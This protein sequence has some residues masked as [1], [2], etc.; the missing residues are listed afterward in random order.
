M[1]V[2]TNPDYP[3]L[4]EA[5]PYPY[6]LIAPDF[7]LIGANPAYLRATGRT[8]NDILGKHI[9]DAFPANPADPDATNIKEVSRSIELAFSTQKPH[10]SALLRY[11]IPRQTEQG[12]VFDERFWSAVHTPV[13]NQQGNVAFVS[14]N[15]ID[16][17]DLYRFDPT[18]KHYFLKPSLNAVPDAA[19][20]ASPLMHEAMTR[21]LS[22]ER[23]QLQMLFNQAPGFIAILMGK[24]HVFEMVNEAYYQLVG[25]RD[26]IGKAVWEALPEVVGQGYEALLNG[27]L[28]SGNAVVLQSQKLLVQRLPNGPLS[29]SY[30]DLVYQPLLDAE[31]RVIGIFAQGHDVTKAYVATEELKKKVQ[32]LEE[33][34]ARQSFQLQIAEILRSHSNPA[35][36]LTKTSKIIGQHFAVSRVLFGDYEVGQKQITFHSNYTDGTVSE[37]AGTFPATAFGLANFEVLEGGSTWV[38]HDTAND[39]RTSGPTVWPSF[40]SSNILSGVA[41]PLNSHGQMIACLFVNAC[42]PRHWTG[43]AVNL[44][45]DAAE[46]IW[47]AVERSRAEGALKQADRRKD[48]FLAMLAHELRNPLAPIGAAAELLQ[49]VKP[50]EQRLRQTSQI[51]GRQ[52]K[53]MTSLVDDL[54]DVSRVTRGLVE[55]DK[56]TYDIRQIVNEAVEQVT[57]L[58]LSKRHH[59]VL[60]LPPETANV[61]G[62]K[63]RLVQVIANLLNNAAK[64]TPEGGNILLK[65]EVDHALVHVDVIDNGVG[66]APELVTRVF[67]LFAQAERSSDRS[68]GGLGLGLA[69]VK[70]LIELHR[71]TVSCQSKGI[72]EGS[73]FRVCMPR[74]I[75]DGSQAEPAQNE[76]ALHSQ[77]AGLR[78]L[79]VDDNQDAAAMLAMLLEAS[80][81]QVQVEHGPHRAL[82]LAKIERPQVCLLDIGLPEMNGN[83]LARRLRAQSENTNVVLIAVT[84]YGQENDRL[85]SMSAGFDYHLVKPIDTQKLAS[86]LNAVSKS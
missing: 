71:G 41:V 86:I 64:Y 58:I 37:I 62:D 69:L 16:V 74:L 39:P 78:I 59:L 19:E 70:S 75:V 61:C 48:E 65:T 63:K 57:P 9:F 10:T 29:E 11:A 81:H 7:T 15:A 67:D 53:H 49:I 44:I 43:D 30:I 24:T 66:M 12:I 4:F 36:I 22:A 84:G 6:L 34:R 13:F 80:G 8:A 35:E 18:S 73:T 25:H 56:K 46:R 47:S 82:E 23:N 55:L 32:E 54:L 3:A 1:I 60:Q 76:I 77:G 42:E 83:E 51:I 79:V 45:Q 14:Q 20:H 28:E 2:M 85:Q 26:L 5:S 21:I 31:N 38:S 68:S 17:T 50:D 40:L 52:V 72:G 33:A 27:V